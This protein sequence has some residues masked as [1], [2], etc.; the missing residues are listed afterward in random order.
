[1][2]LQIWQIIVLSMILFN[3]INVAIKHGEPYGDR[4]LSKIVLLSLGYLIVYQVSYYFGEFY[5]IIRAPQ[6]LMIIFA[7]TAVLS[8]IA[9]GFSNKKKI[10]LIGNY[11]IGKQLIFSFVKLGLL[12]WGGFFT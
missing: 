5:D 9:I 2:N 3:V 11:N 12:Y 6:I 4:S 7:S 8:T 10:Q 1:M